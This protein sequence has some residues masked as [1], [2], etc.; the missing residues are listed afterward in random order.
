METCLYM[1]MGAIKLLQSTSFTTMAC[2]ARAVKPL[3]S[4]IWARTIQG[5]TPREQLDRA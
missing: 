2:E 5:I 4:G 3:N 1:T